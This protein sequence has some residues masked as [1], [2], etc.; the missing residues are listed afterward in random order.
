MLT[1]YLL[2]QS[3]KM[4]WLLNDYGTYRRPSYPRSTEVQLRSMRKTFVLFITYV[5]D[6]DSERSSSSLREI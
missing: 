2:S 3:C 4:H 5:P 1:F 6:L